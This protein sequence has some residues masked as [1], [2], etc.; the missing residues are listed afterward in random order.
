MFLPSQ[1]VCQSVRA[2]L[3]ERTAAREELHN[4]AFQDARGN[5]LLNDVKGFLRQ[6]EVKQGNVLEFVPVIDNEVELILVQRARY[7]CC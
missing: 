3:K 5:V 6:R 7:T 1:S 4:A 2:C